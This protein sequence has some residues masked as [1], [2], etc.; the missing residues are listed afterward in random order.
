MSSTIGGF[1]TARSV[2]VISPEAE[3]TRE[4]PVIPVQGYFY[5]YAG[6]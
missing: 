5:N 2:F 1:L 6:D 4:T 3:E